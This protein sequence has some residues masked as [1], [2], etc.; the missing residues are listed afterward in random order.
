VY[1]VAGL[2]ASVA[3]HPPEPSTRPWTRWPSAV[4]SCA[5]FTA[6]P[7]TVTTTGVSGRTPREPSAGAT[8]TVGALRTDE[9][10]ATEALPPERS[11]TADDEQPAAATATTTAATTARTRVRTTALLTW[12]DHLDRRRPGERRTNAARGCLRTP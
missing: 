11:K 3:C 1:V 2:R 10:A 8:E 6:P 5:V 7:L 4:V 9:V 12:I